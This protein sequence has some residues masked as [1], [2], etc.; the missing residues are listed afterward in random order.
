MKKVTYAII[1]VISRIHQIYFLQAIDCQ[2]IILVFDFSL[3]KSEVKL[4]ENGKDGKPADSKKARRRLKDVQKLLQE[5]GCKD[6]GDIAA[7]IAN[8]MLSL[9]Q[10]LMQICGKVKNSE[11]TLGQQMPD[12]I[13]GGISDSDSE[14]ASGSFRV[15]TP[16]HIYAEIG[17]PREPNAYLTPRN[18]Q[19]Q[20]GNGTS[21][22]MA[23]TFEN[24][25]RPEKH[26]SVQMFSSDSDSPEEARPDFASL[27]S[28]CQS[29]PKP[30]AI[31]PGMERNNARDDVREES[32]SSAVDF[33]HNSQSLPINLMAHPDGQP[34]RRSSQPSLP[35]GTPTTNVQMKQHSF[36][37]PQCHTNDFKTPPQNDF[38]VNNPLQKR[39]TSPD[40]YLQHQVPDNSVAK[41][42]AMI[43]T[44]PVNSQA[45][46]S[47]YDDPGHTTQ[48]Q[49]TA[50][51]ED[52]NLSPIS[53]RSP[54]RRQLPAVP[55]RSVSASLG[56]GHDAT[57]ING[58]RQH[59]SDNFDDINSKTDYK[60]KMGT[61]HNGDPRTNGR[62][63]NNKDSRDVDIR[64]EHLDEEEIKFRESVKYARDEIM[65]TLKRKHYVNIVPGQSSL[66]ADQVPSYKDFQARVD[67][68]SSPCFTGTPKYDSIHAM[69]VNQD[70]ALDKSSPGKIFSRT[71]DSYHE[72]QYLRDM[73]RENGMNHDRRNFKLPE[74]Q[75]TH[76]TLRDMDSIVASNIRKFESVIWNNNGDKD[77]RSRRYNWVNRQHFGSRNRSSSEPRIHT[78][79]LNPLPKRTSKQSTPQITRSQHFNTESKESP[80]RETIHDGFQKHEPSPSRR[81]CA[82]RKSCSTEND[83]HQLVKNETSSRI[84]QWSLRRS[85][86]F[87]GKSPNLKSMERAPKYS[88]S[89]SFSLPERMKRCHISSMSIVGNSKVVV[90]D[91]RNFYLHL[92]DQGFRHVFERKLFDI[93]RRCELIGENYV[94][95]ALPYKRALHHYCIGNAIITLEKEVSLSCNAW[96]VDIAFAQ[97]SLYVLCKGGHIHRM[98]K[99]GVEEHCISIGMSGRLFC[100]PS[101]KRLYVIGEGRVSKFDMEGKLI[102]SHSDIDAHSI[103]FLENQTYVADRQRHRI[104]PLTD[105]LDVQ[106]LTADKIEYPT[107]V[108]TS[109]TNDKLFVSQYE[110]CLDDVATRTIKVFE[111]NKT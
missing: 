54:Q 58:T 98:T 90:L 57:K 70:M 76:P 42:T 94:V 18:R 25:F 3:S 82:L 26:R 51:R 45:A 59:N 69:E 4:K 38:L 11:S 107:A 37:S 85:T 27:S 34:H 62:H 21:K 74:G 92:F 66:Q 20:N 8:Q 31:F 71:F 79:P 33:S 9:C 83:L 103:L 100:H 81:Q 39:I 104:V 15:T 88:F 10:K 46:K 65:D 110:E 64:P 99:S 35:R 80:Q 48:K 43:L 73:N 84:R 13:Q 63:G 106:D 89:C 75:I 72:K 97:N 56:D 41:K 55:N 5:L 49:G 40:K 53:A 108:C 77:T 68:R 22:S 109:I 36:S 61:C 60:N 14:E 6:D 102:S 105:A 87:K 50:T 7:Y 28:L 93:P 111:L 96:I 2:W 47:R 101:R 12:A 95:V 17:S 67:A 30:L 23:I 91:E 1:K 29:T 52:Q 32:L 86:S 24:A 44:E 19:Q 16:K 78:L